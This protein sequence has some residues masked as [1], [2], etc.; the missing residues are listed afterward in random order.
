MSARACLDV[1]GWVATVGAIVA[2]IAGFDVA[3]IALVSLSS[4]LIL[5]DIF[6]NEKDG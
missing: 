2:I 6:L 5:G 3:A 1:V 4:G